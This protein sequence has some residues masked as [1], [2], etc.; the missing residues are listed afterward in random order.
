MGWCVSAWRA[1]RISGYG[2][3]L[4]VGVLTGMI[5]LG[6]Q[7]LMVDVNPQAY[8][9]DAQSDRLTEKKEKLITDFVPSVLKDSNFLMFMLYFSV[10]T[11]AVNLRGP[12]FNIYLLKDLSLDVSL[13][14]IYSS[15]S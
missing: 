7:F 1:D 3:V 15:L 4:F 9:Q 12:F 13:V 2:M 8:R 6:Y 14:T 10:W 5:G 11:F